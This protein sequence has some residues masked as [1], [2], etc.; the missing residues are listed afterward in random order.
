M[1]ASAGDRRPLADDARSAAW[2]DRTRAIFGTAVV[3]V[4]NPAT[5]ARHCSGFF[6]SDELIVTSTACLSAEVR[7]GSTAVWV[8][9]ATVATPEDADAFEGILGRRG[10]GL[11][12]MTGEGDPWTLPVYEERVFSG[13]L[14][15]YE[16]EERDRP[17]A[18]LRCEL[19]GGLFH[20][21][22][23]FGHLELATE[24]PRA[25]TPLHG[26]AMDEL[27]GRDAIEA[28]VSPGTM[29][30]SITCPSGVGAGCFE[31]TADHTSLGIGGP[32]LDRDHRVVGVMAGVS[33]LV[34]RVTTGKKAG[35]EMEVDPSSSWADD[36]CV[37]ETYRSM[38]LVGA[39]LGVT[40]GPV[41][42]RLIQDEREPGA[43]QG[44]YFDATEQIGHMSYDRVALTC[45]E[46]MQ[47][48][49]VIG[50]TADKGMVGNLGVVCAPTDAHLYDQAVVHAKDAGDVG[51]FQDPGMPLNRYLAE[52]RSDNQPILG[53]QTFRVCPEGTV[54]R[55]IQATTWD[56][57]ER[58]EALECDGPKSR[59][60]VPI[61]SEAHGWIGSTGQGYLK[62]TRCPA[63]TAIAGLVVTAGPET[64]GFHATCREV[65]PLP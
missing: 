23:A 49:G 44:R 45:P 50:S 39:N 14:C 55:G 9:G 65:V 36:P 19:N 3:D 59:T 58:V 33:H 25:G 37:A 34:A 15:F 60:L 28:V 52:A 54:L 2:D 7:D 53:T 27:C 38:D 10:H 51:K 12:Y 30:A 35:Y 22:E 42:R 6:A 20:P 43:V 31:H 40:I 16:A 13:G 57:V 47:A 62:A 21:G 4:F 5:E 56:R 41:G 1:L 17:I 8:R 24:R 18:Y 46:H 11:G 63:G 32:L 61:G 64:E 29:G 48:V 26:L